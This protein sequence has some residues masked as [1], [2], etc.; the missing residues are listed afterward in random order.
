[1]LPGLVALIVQ[2][3]S[4]IGRTT[5]AVNEHTVGVL[6]IKVVTPLG[7]ETSSV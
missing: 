4:F 1:V 5:K 6:E 3:P 2:T 7:A